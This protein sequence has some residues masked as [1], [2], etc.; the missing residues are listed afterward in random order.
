[1]KACFLFF[2]VFGFL[3]IGCSEEIDECFPVLRINYITTSDVDSVR[4]Y[5][6]DER[7]CVET[8]VFDKLY[9]LNCEKG[10]LLYSI[11]FR[12]MIDGYDTT[13]IAHDDGDVS[14]W[15]LSPNSSLWKYYEC[16]VDESKKQDIDSSKLILL[17][18]SNGEEKHFQSREEFLAGNHYNIVSVQDTASWY[19]YTR[20]M[21]PGYFD[22]YGSPDAWTR[23]GCEEGF[24]IANQSAKEVCH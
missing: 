9:C 14:N 18:Y 15:P 6:N 1:M 11:I 20:S 17:V 8:A 22:Y 24:C 16:V 19:S 10:M 13:L 4:F 5:L 21:W 3:F 2:V 7:V 23:D 12:T